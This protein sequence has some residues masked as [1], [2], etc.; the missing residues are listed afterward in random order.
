MPTRRSLVGILAERQLV[1]GG[2][3]NLTLSDT[4]NVLFFIGRS[5]PLYSRYV[6][7]YIGYT[8]SVYCDAAMNRRYRILMITRNFPPT[9]GGME[10]LAYHAYLELSK[11]FDVWLLGPSD[12]EQ[13]V[14]DRTRLVECR[15]KPLAAFLLCLQ[16]HASRLARR[17]GFDLVF[18]SSGMSALAASAAARAARV[19]VITCVHGLD[20][21]VQHALYRTFFLPAIRRSSRLIANSRHTAELAC[22]IGIGRDAIEILHPGVSID[23]GRDFSAS[24]RFRARYGLVGRKLLLSVGRLL[25]RKGLPEFIRHVMPTLVAKHSDLTLAIIG[26][27][28]RRALAAGHG[29]LLRIQQAVISSGMNQHVNVLGAVDDETL[30]Q[31]FADSDLFVF[32][33]REI[34]GD[35][36]GFGM[37]ALEA[38]VF[39]LPTVAFSVGGVADAVGVG[40]SGYLIPPGD[41]EQLARAV[42]RYFDSESRALWRN[43]CIG[44]A[45][46]F[47]WEEYGAKLRKIC[48]DTIKNRLTE[49]LRT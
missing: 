32:P 36:E 25:P 19:P 6:L 11:E 30:H 39:G 24:G 33:V 31:A 40:T 28:P 42:L 15:T 38:A 5:L 47:S 20:I 37:V 3:A 22:D 49:R 12:S 21:V 43:R 26:E 44:H 29:E 10:R 16:W 48:S 35:I 27:E 4:G 18:A 2:V 1:G 14:A 45:N 9:I 7:L 46:R 41:Y 34:P 23:G 17:T 13:Y 8:I